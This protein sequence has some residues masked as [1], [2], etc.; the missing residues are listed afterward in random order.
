MPELPEVETVRKGLESRLEN[1][2]ID[3]VEVLLER[4]IASPGGP[5]EFKHRLKGAVFLAWFRRG[6]Y[7]LASIKADP[8]KSKTNQRTKV[9]HSGILGVH[10]RMTGHFQWITKPSPACKHTRVRFWNTNGDELRFVD[11]RS[12]GQ[13]WWV[14]QCFKP[15]E[16]ISGL[17]NLGP[18]PFSSSFNSTYLKRRFKGSKR[19]IKSALLDQSVVAGVGNIYADE[20][21][22]LSKINP[23][24]PSGCLTRIQLDQLHKY[25]INVLTLS[26][27]SG[28]TT[29]SDFRDI[30]G[31]NGNYGGQAWV[32]RKTGVACRKC[33]TPI[34]RTKLSGRSTHWCPSCQE[35]L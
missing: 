31:V 22:F 29:F 11:I 28:G 14:D 20:S 26:I 19:P 6:K 1:F 27:G 32:Y 9:L 2:Q 8:K 17:R 7:L 34:I 25:L 33:N 13:M 23:H 3:K 10:L 30:E 4:V 16:I 35:A 15:E 12:F 21:L 24:T 18:E 5:S